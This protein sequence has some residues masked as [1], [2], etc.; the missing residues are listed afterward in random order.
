VSVQLHASSQGPAGH[1]S[2]RLDTDS[3]AVRERSLLISLRT[4]QFQR[5]RWVVLFLRPP[6]YSARDLITSRSSAPCPRIAMGTAYRSRWMQCVDRIAPRR[7]STNVL[8]DVTPAEWRLLLGSG[9]L[10]KRR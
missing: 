1:A 2:F 9:Y 7:S 10:V 4:V 8:T 5:A 6:S 3:Q